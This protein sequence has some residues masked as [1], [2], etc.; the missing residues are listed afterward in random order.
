MEIAQRLRELRTIMQLTQRDIS[1]RS[2][3][4]VPYISRVECGD[5]MPTL[6]AVEKWSRALSIPIAYL[7]AG[8][9]ASDAGGKAQTGV[10]LSAEEKR[11]LALLKRIEKRDRR[12]LYS[13][14]SKMT[15]LNA[16]R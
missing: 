16:E 14:G 12:L 10:L 9:P 5:L 2:G 7:F 1:E 4:T 13:I 3:L 8:V 6:E 15:K 11:F